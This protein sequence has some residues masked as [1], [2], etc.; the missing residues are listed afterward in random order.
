MPLFI[1]WRLPR[2]ATTGHRSLSRATR[3]RPTMAPARCGRRRRAPRA[4]G[5]ACATPRSR[6][7][8]REGSPPLS[9]SDISD[10]RDATLYPLAAAARRDDRPSVAQHSDPLAPSRCRIGRAGAVGGVERRELRGRRAQHPDRDGTCERGHRRSLAL[11]FRTGGMPLFIHWRLPRAATTGHRSLSTATRWRRRLAD[12]RCRRGGRRRRA[13]RA[14]GSA[15]ATPRSRRHLREGSPPLS[16]SDISDW[17]DATLYPL[18]AAARRDDRPSVAQHSD[19]LA[20][21]RWRRRGARRRRAPRATGS[22]CA[23]PRS[24]R[25]L[26]EG[27]TAA[28]SL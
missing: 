21:Y 10:W 9:R 15:C 25:H 11:T 28:L 14:T 8:L 20:S 1:H 5:S 2:A 12:P 13:P 24:R 19:P 7:H 26:R 6:R 4:T 17:R 27:V 23:T 18:A 3:W 16:R 22:A